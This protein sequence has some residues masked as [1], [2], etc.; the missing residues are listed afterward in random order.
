MQRASRFSLWRLWPP[1]RRVVTVRRI[2][3]GG[4]LDL[5]RLLAA[6]L[7]TVRVESARSI[8]EADVL[9]VMGESEL[10][11]FADLV[12]DGQPVGYLRAW[13]GGYGM[14]PMT[15]WNIQ[16]LLAASR[17][18]EGDGGWTRI[19]G[20][21]RLDPNPPATEQKGGLMADV[22]A[23][24]RMLGLDPMAIRSWSMQEFIDMRETL[25]QVLEQEKPNQRED[26]AREVSL[27]EL[28]M[29]I[30]GIALVH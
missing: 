20:C 12:T 19:L 14:G 21:L 28:S 23:L 25:L 17:E 6:R 24:S 27:Q 11:A 7:A 29:S 9:R 10:C 30:P 18:A 3:V 2:T 15:H 1:F 4:F 8:T 13:L 16:K 5:V 26:G 22:V